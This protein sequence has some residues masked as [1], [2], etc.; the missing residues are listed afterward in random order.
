MKA[1]LA[2]LILAVTA[3]ALATSGVAWADGICIDPNGGKCAAIGFFDWLAQLF[4]AGGD[5]GFGMDP[6]G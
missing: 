2:T 3:A 5:Q 1:R 6:N 4:S